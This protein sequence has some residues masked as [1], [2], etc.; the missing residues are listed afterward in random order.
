M[1]EHEWVIENLETFSA[2]GL[3]PAER[4]R[5]DHHLSECAECRE[6][7]AVNE[8]LEQNLEKILGPNKP[9]T[10][11]DNRL[12]CRLRAAQPRPWYMRKF[13]L[14][15]AAM[16]GIGV[17]GGVASHVIET[18]KFPEMP[19]A[20]APPADELRNFQGNI[21]QGQAIGQSH[22]HVMKPGFA[23][24]T[25]EVLQET[26]AK[27]AP[28]RT[29]DSSITQGRSDREIFSPPRVTGGTFNFS[30]DG[31][32]SGEPSGGERVPDKGA[33]NELARNTPLERSS[34]VETKRLDFDKYYKPSLLPSDSHAA[35]V[36]SIKKEG[37]ESTQPTYSQPLSAATGPVNQAG[38]QAGVDDE[39]AQKTNLQKNPKSS[40]DRK[41]Q[42]S[43]GR[44]VIRSGTI[45]F[46]IQSFDAAV[47]NITRLVNDIK[48]GYV[49][50]VN[51]EKLPNGKV[52]GTVVVRVPPEQLDNLILD[53]RAQLGKGG[54][55]KSLRVGSEDITKQYTDME[56]RLKA[57]RTMEERLLQVIKS[58][59]GEIKDLV[60]A[61]REL[62]VWHTKIEEIEGELRYF[63]NLVSLSTL[64]ITLYEREIKAPY[65][66]TETER[67]QMGI[68]VEDVDQT[69]RKVLAAVTG[70]KGRITKSELRQ[71]DAGQLS[72]VVDFEVAREAAGPLRDR[73]RQLGTVTRLD[74]ERLQ[75]TEGGTGNA[76]DAKIKR[77]DTQFFVSL[78][79]MANVAPRETMQM[80][81]AC[82]DVEQVYR[83]I[84][85]R[86]RKASGR[87]VTSN[88]NRQRGSDTSGTI[89]FEVKSA[90]APAM[91][92]ELKLVAELMRLQVTE[93]PDVQNV[94]KAK[95]GFNVQL[96]SF[97]QVQPR[98]VRI[99]RVAT[100]DVAG[101]FRALRDAVAK[102]KGFVM[103]AQL[104]EQDKQRITAQLDFDA[105]V[106]DQPALNLAV[107][108]IG[109]TLSSDASRA[110]DGEYVLDSKVRWQVS[111][112]NQANIP[113]RDTV[114]LGL[115]VPDVDKTATAF[116]G[117]VTAV[118]GRT[119][120]ATITHER[121]GQ[122]TAKLVYN[123]P[124][125]SKDDLVDKIKGSGQ[126]R[127][128]QSSRNPQVP[129]S[130]L[131]LA[132]L[133]VTLSNVELIV[134]QDD[135]FWTQI[136]RGLSTSFR[137]LSWSLM[138]VIVGACVI[139]PWSLAAYATFRVVRRLRKAAAE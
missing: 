19:I 11:L 139:L 97:G 34:R 6:A 128:E 135:G 82:A 121:S 95:R 22:L 131:A 92:Q 124:L 78:Y 2:G 25:A 49:D 23:S 42:S 69:H 134:P 89:Q 84:L 33:S 20:L 120:E 138:V 75:Q 37:T 67:V 7:L 113:P 117:L 26:D 24:E 87:I 103:N 38:Q 62:G 31:R 90:D 35:K 48:N 99:L 58:G 106:T 13:V 83:Q 55:L 123:V 66:I 111:L 43:A 109:D 47:A 14:G 27:N 102:A 125:A 126:V 136:R 132:R 61:E 65:G 96:L 28:I 50:T 29:I 64:T 130:A 115:E 56:S 10:N 4:E 3:D 71:H 59:K 51:S 91:L 104:N 17:V 122:V 46:E 100:R 60:Q 39:E 114:I 73:L 112:I 133:E 119:A 18:G 108:E 21:R 77:N 129:E 15:A 107:T 116:S 63:N 79:N 9:D 81:L 36:D 80:S 44:K 5:L 86:V 45:E 52:R 40:Q 93:N 127:L 53:L 8:N 70:A 74:V 76:V 41:Q 12:I 105:H 101:G 32:T 1:S 72:A 94:T 57:A 118:H 137:A 110:A 88:L 98:E 16:V 85:D 68:E 30:K 54:E